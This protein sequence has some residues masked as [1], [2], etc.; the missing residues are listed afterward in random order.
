VL[1]T[2]TNSNTNIYHPNTV[3]GDDVCLLRHHLI[4][5]WNHYL[6]SSALS[7]WLATVSPL[8]I[9]G[10]FS[11]VPV[12]LIL[13]LPCFFYKKTPMPVGPPHFKMLSTS[14]D[15]D[16]ASI[17][18]FFWYNKVSHLL[19]SSLNLDPAMAQRIDL[20]GCKLLL[21]SLLPP[22]SLSC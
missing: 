2:T 16:L 18:S 15:L 14:L 21:F 22:R 11:G 19:P 10:T 1:K 7:H 4:L 8:T 17:G 5:H 20:V 12:L 6:C 9:L 3:I 13:S